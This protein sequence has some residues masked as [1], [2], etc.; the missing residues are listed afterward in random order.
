MQKFIQMI[1]NSKSIWKVF[2]LLDENLYTFCY[3]WKMYSRYI[4]WLFYKLLHNGAIIWKRKTFR[5]DRMTPC[6]FWPK[7]PN[8]LWL[9]ITDPMVL[10]AFSSHIVRPSQANPSSCQSS[11]HLWCSPPLPHRRRTRPHPTRLRASPAFTVSPTPLPSTPMPLLKGFS[12]AVRHPRGQLRKRPPRI[13]ALDHHAAGPAPPSDLHT[14][15]PSTPRLRVATMSPAPHL[16]GAIMPPALRLRWH[17]RARRATKQHDT[18]YDKVFCFRFSS[19][20]HSQI[21]WFVF[22]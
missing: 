16:H 15:A 5:W 2:K 4:F 11:S 8:L 18:R 3:V 7:W 14:S 6:L 20:S 17:L 12:A 21:L 22:A 10:I 19:A 1:E 13:A 9:F